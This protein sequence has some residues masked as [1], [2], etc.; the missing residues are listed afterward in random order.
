MSKVASLEAEAEFNWDAFVQLPKLETFDALTGRHNHQLASPNMS[1]WLSNSCRLHASKWRHLTA[2]QTS[3]KNNNASQGKTTCMHPMRQ[4]ESMFAWL[5]GTS[6]SNSSCIL[7]FMIDKLEFSIRHKP[8]APR[9]SQSLFQ[10]RCPGKA[11]APATNGSL[12][13]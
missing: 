10:D 11:T 2:D 9:S 7:E 13:N 5:C 8:G 12:N 6:M 4:T 1:E 3:A